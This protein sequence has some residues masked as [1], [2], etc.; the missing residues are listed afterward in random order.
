L[1]WVRY[2]VITIFPELIESAL[3]VGLLGKALGAGLCELACVNPRDFTVDKHRSVDD[4]P[5]G[6]GSGM[7]MSAP[8]LVAALEHLDAEADRL[9]RSRGRKILLSPSGAR[10]DQAAARRLAAEPALTLISGRY[11]G[12]DDRLSAWV[13]E[14]LSLGDFVLNGGEVAALAI[15]EATA[16][17]VPGVLGNESSIV[18]ESHAAGLLE[19][20]QFTRPRVFRDREVPAVLLSGDHAQ[21]ARY[22]RREALARTR[23]QRPDLF[24]RLPLTAAD[25]T[26]L[27]DPPSAPVY[28]A[29]VHH[30]VRDR[31][32]LTVTSAITN[33]DVHDVARSAH[34]YGLRG[35][36]IVSP[37]EAQRDLVVKILEH[38]R[39]G[40]GKRRMPH[41]SEALATAHAVTSI[42]E[43]VEWIAQREGAQPLRIATAARPLLGRALTR[44]EEGKSLLARGSRP[45]LILFGTG[46]GLAD[47]V[48]QSADYLLE[49][50]AGVGEYNHLSVRAAAAIVFDRLFGRSF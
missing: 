25:R 28:A 36:S 50:I 23:A 26:L 38:W 33:I 20:P 11:E 4:T 13:D 45:A 40:S 18:E 44:F 27:D 48:L 9:G 35:L 22:R 5:Y 16:R 37:I 47:E 39:T 46:H 24:A 12:I 34:T 15:I 43:A 49:P 41:R 3:R 1:S 2:E 19:Y 31:E 30:P 42:D 8:P 32:G 21:I 7:V 17:L 10:F 29:L 6:G 14:S